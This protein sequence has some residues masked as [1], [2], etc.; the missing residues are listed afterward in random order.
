MR[1]NVVE[2]QGLKIKSFYAEKLHKTSKKLTEEGM[3]EGLEAL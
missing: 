3:A 1:W 2:R